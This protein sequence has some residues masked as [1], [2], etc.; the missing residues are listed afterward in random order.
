MGDK[1]IKNDMVK[2]KKKTDLNSPAPSSAPRT[3][4][5]QPELIKKKK[6]PL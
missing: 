1:S 4:M 5:P 6:K 3:I 2:K